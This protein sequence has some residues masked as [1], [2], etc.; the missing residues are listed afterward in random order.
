VPAAIARD[1]H[2]PFKPGDEVN[3]QIDAQRLIIGPKKRAKKGVIG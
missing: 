2:F 1:A 3:I